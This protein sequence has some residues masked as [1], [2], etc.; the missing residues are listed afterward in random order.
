VTTDF[1]IEAHIGRSTP[2]HP[3]DV[4]AVHWQTREDASLADRRTEEGRAAL[5]MNPGRV[6]ILVDVRLKL[7]VRRHLVPFAAFRMQP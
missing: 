2:D 1:R 3:V 7:V 6:Q 4:N 5:A